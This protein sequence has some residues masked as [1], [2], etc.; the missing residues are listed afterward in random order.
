MSV[1]FDLTW[2]ALKAFMLHMTRYVGNND[3][4]T[5]ILQ[6][7]WNCDV[8]EVK[9]ELGI[10]DNPT[11]MKAK[12]M[13]LLKAV[14]KQLKALPFRHVLTT[15]CSA[16]VTPGRQWANGGNTSLDDFIVERDCH[17]FTVQPGH[18]I[19]K[20]KRAAA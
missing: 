12:V 11:L 18:P 4:N 16:T 2:R 7:K 3:T 14:R 1:K 15:S 20:R 8:T 5:L 17:I 10:F 9:Q 19:I 13:A 6:S